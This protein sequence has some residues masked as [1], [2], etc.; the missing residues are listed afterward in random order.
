MSKKKIDLTC[1]SDSRL[2]LLGI[3]TLLVVFFHSDYLIIDNIFSVNFF[4]NILKFIQKTG[5]FGVDLFLLL[6]GVGLYFSFS[7]N[8]IKTFYKNRFKRI[9]PVF[10]IVTIIY[11]M[12]T[13]TMTI[14]EI[15]ETLF[16]LSFFVKGNADVWFIPFI[17]IM[18]LI[19][20]LI[21]KIIK[22]KDWHGLVIL[23][24]VTMLFNFLYSVCLPVNYLYIELAL[25]RIPVFL[26]GVYLGKLIFLKKKIGLNI[27][28]ISFLSQILIIFILYVN[29]NIERF[30]I[31]ARYFYC[32]LSISSVINISFLFSMLKNREILF[33][34][35]IEFFGLFSLE[36]YLIYE[37]VE[38][39]LM[40]CYKYDSIVVFYIFCFLIT[41]LLSIVVKKI[42]NMLIILCN[43]FFI[44]INNLNKKNNKNII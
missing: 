32:L 9:L 36:I 7:K 19:F 35:I 37:K 33:V 38:Y 15:L 31:F 3:A 10:I 34:K 25:T 4:T 30:S 24:F 6:S 41:I 12:I 27:F 44:L 28:F 1:I 17:M 43:K 39:I 18:Y 20:P 23:L 40:K 26:C 8:K 13:K 29:L 2:F 16:F 14:V 5:N 21:Y 42:V 11:A 22:E